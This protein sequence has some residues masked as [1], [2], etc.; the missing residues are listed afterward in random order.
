M[1]E[2]VYELTSNHPDRVREDPEWSLEFPPGFCPWCRNIDRS[3]YPAPVDVGILEIP[4]RITCGIVYPFGAYVFCASLVERL[5]EDLVASGFVFGKCLDSDGDVIEDYVTCYPKDYIVLRGNA[6][7]KYYICEECG[8][9][10]STVHGFPYVLRR[11]LTD[12]TIYQRTSGR[13][14]VADEIAMDVDWGQWPDLELRLTRILD[15]PIDGQRL[16]GDPPGE[17]DE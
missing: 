6:A 14:Y 8:A 11:Q 4:E 7:T 2:T 1:I 12:A 17:Q 10:D 9:V 5:H 15:K 16:P 13:V 3:R